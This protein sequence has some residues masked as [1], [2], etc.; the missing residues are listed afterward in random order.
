MQQEQDYQ[1]W[2]GEVL[3]Q[4]QPLVLLL[5]GRQEEEDLPGRV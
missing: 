2:L 3:V 4:E 5:W 1:D